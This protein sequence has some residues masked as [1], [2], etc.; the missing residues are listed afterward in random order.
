MEPDSGKIIERP[1]NFEIQVNYACE[2]EVSYQKKLGED[3]VSVLIQDCVPGFLYAISQEGGTVRLIPQVEE[4]HECPA[5][6]PTTIQRCPN[7]MKPKRSCTHKSYQNLDGSNQDAP[8]RKSAYSCPVYYCKPGDVDKI[9]NYANGQRWAKDLCTRVDLVEG[10]VYTTPCD[11]ATGQCSITTTLESLAKRGEI[12]VELSDRSKDLL[13]QLQRA[14]KALADDPNNEAL[15]KKVE[16]LSKDW[17]Q[18]KLKDI[19]DSL[20]R[21]ASVTKIPLEVIGAEIKPRSNEEF[22]S[23]FSGLSTDCEGGGVCVR[24]VVRKT[25]DGQEYL[26]LPTGELVSALYPEQSAEKIRAG[27]SKADE[28]WMETA[29][30]KFMPQEG[31]PNW[32]DR[33]LGLPK[34]LDPEVLG[35][36]QERG[37]ELYEVQDLALQI[38]NITEGKLRVKDESLEGGKS[39]K[40]IIGF[41]MGT[42]FSSPIPMIGARKFAV[43]LGQVVN[44]LGEF[45]QEIWKSPFLPSSELRVM[46]AE[47]MFGISGFYADD[48][49]LFSST[50]ESF[51]KKD[52]FT[53]EMGHKVIRNLLTAE[54]IDWTNPTVP[55]EA[56]KE[57]SNYVYGVPLGGSESLDSF[58]PSLVFGD[59]A[60]GNMNELTAEAFKLYIEDPIGFKLTAD[61]DPQM[62][63][64]Q[65]VLDAALYAHGVQ[66]PLYTR[67]TPN[68]WARTSPF[69]FPA[70]DK[71][72][73]YTSEQLLQWQTETDAL[74]RQLFP[75]Y[76]NNQ[77]P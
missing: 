37:A 43:E 57:V 70:G 6:A 67:L 17:N 47:N 63:K 39:V 29:V 50:F 45:P 21:T 27:M 25:Q 23:L 42:I 54:P 71:P 40:E 76:R 30:D 69:S 36:L 41:S 32:Y 51:A 61:K 15:K 60:I 2:R 62:Q 18:S 38:G 8:E 12:P 68:T 34:G 22:V 14:E 20:E 44:Q 64:I 5:N 10:I 48:I 24:E 58:Q 55:N 52:V 35:A 66:E 3:P 7:G 73:T 74:A 59:Y 75:V 4:A 11:E 53:H 31:V 19:K 49:I 26:V 33:E 9:S 65:N 72:I 1:T 16:A 77:N 46:I 13:Q 28:S 56:M